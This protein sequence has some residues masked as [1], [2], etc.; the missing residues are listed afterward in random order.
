MRSTD[1]KAV[2]NLTTPK[3]TTY[4]RPSPTKVVEKPDVSY[5]VI[6]DGSISKQKLPGEDQK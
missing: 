6:R 2:L 1:T 3:K 5:T 4:R